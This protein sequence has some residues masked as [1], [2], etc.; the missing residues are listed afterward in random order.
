MSN[1]PDLVPILWNAPYDAYHLKPVN[2]RHIWHRQLRWDDLNA[3]PTRLRKSNMYVCKKCGSEVCWTE[4][5]SGK[6]YLVNVTSKSSRY[7]RRGR[8]S[9][10][11]YYFSPAD[12]HSKTCTPTADGTVHANAIHHENRNARLMAERDAETAPAPEP[13]TDADWQAMHDEHLAG[14]LE[15]ERINEAMEDAR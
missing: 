3:L 15:D 1:H 4:S 5:K 2:A 6:R 11:D 9:T 14:A 8:Y 7:G 12:W 13:M 10:T